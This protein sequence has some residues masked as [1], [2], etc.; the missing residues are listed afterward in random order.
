[1]GRLRAQVVEGVS[2]FT[3]LFTALLISLGTEVVG[4]CLRDMFVT[5]RYTCSDRTFCATTV[6]G[7][8]TDTAVSILRRGKLLKPLK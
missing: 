3:H 1:M 5:E 7:A 2:L 4:G 6:A 8:R